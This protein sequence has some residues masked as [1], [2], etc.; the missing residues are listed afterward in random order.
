M[1]AA[2]SPIFLLNHEL[3]CFSPYASTKSDT[4]YFVIA[5]VPLPELSVNKSIIFS[6]DSIVA[7]IVPTLLECFFAIL[8]GTPISSNVLY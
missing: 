4:V 2:L 8:S 3:T 5:L 7:L 1:F 6:P